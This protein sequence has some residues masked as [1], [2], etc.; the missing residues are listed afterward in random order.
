MQTSNTYFLV[1]DIETSKKM[2]YNE[3]LEKEMPVSVWLSYGV[4]KMYRNNGEC[5][6]T[7]RF[8][9]WK[10]LYDFLNEIN[11]RFEKKIIC[12]VHNLSY[13]FD[14]LIKNLSK[15][16]KFLCNSNHKVI[17]GILEDF[18]HIEFHCTYQLSVQALSKLGEQL[19]LPKLES[20]YRTIYPRDKV[21]EEEWIYCERDC[22]IC[23]LY[24]VEEL[25]EYKLIRN[26]P[27][28]STGKV[29]KDFKE[30]LKQYPPEFN[31]DIMPPENCYNALVK[32]FNGAI[33]MSNPRFTNV[34]LNMKIKSFDEKSKYPGAGL[35]YIY[36]YT[37]EKMETFSQTEYLSHKFW[38]GLVEITDISSKYDWGTLTQSKFEDYDIF[39]TEF[40]NGK[41]MSSKRVV[42]YITNVDLEIINMVYNYK[43]STFLEFYKCDNYAK[44]P[45]AFIELIKKYAKPKYELGL[46]LKELKKQGKENTIEFIEIDK[47]YMK[48]KAKLNSIYG[49]MVQKLVSPEYYIDEH[50]FWYEKMPEYKRSD[51]HICRNFLYGIFITAYSRL[52]IVKNIIHNCPY[53]FVYCD[54]DSI[55]Y[56]DIGTEFEDLNDYIPK[57]LNDLPYLK[58]FNR[59]EEE[60]DYTEFI[61]YGA[62]KYAFI[63]NNTFGYTV[64]GLPKHNKK[65]KGFSDFYLGR[66][67]KNCKHGKRY[68]YEQTF[69]DTDTFGFITDTSK[70]NSDSYTQGGIAIFDT[71]YKLSMTR[72]DLYYIERN[73]DIWQRKDIQQNMLVKRY[74][75]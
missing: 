52:D 24:V 43:E 4:I 58:N 54:T 37:I 45:K 23:A 28:T 47:E 42:R 62:K 29:R 53:T 2:E 75:G 69:I 39:S 36:P 27:L 20:E 21:T 57:E 16:S 7:L 10:K 46:K 55:K 65:I 68:I 32:T 70:R 12:F 6:K 11:I 30:M 73:K 18:E 8:R 15:P 61:T 19:N 67:F 3:K 22:D 26:I 25:K 72:E 34:H 14:F 41:L 56:I 44:L 40:F 64:A 51:K 74:A 5:T 13:E 33:T 31:W 66:T 71:D 50:Y 48:A 17:S 49:M 9:N 38:I 63:K 35:A 60:D 59:F 1:L